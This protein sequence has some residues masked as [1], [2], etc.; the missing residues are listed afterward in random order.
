MKDL[1]E[2]LNKLSQANDIIQLFQTFN[3]IILELKSK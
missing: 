3:N 2:W 1:V